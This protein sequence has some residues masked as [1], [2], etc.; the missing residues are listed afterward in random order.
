MKA[1]IRIAGQIGLTKNVKETLDRLRIRRKYACVVVKETPVIKGMLKKVVNFVAYGDISKETFVEL[2]TKRGQSV[3]KKK[4]INAA[5]A[6]EEL[7]KGKK[8]SEVGLK[9]FFRLHPARGGINTKVHF[10]KG[11]LGNH[12]EKINELIKRML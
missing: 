5:K 6:V 7:E 4:K 10:P 12:K 2:L 1:I 9:P 11:V 8:Y 3:D